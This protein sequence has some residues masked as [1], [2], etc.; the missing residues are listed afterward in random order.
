MNTF[1]VGIET[2]L[3][4]E[5]LEQLLSEA[6]GR[7]NDSRWRGPGFNPPVGMITVAAMLARTDNQ[8]DSQYD[9]G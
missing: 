2:S 3:T 9:A 1:V 6:K 7:A 4:K 8:T 5:E